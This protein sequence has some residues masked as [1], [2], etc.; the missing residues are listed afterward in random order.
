M[1][2]LG[3]ELNNKKK[4]GEP[5][6]NILFA[7]LFVS[8]L[9]QMLFATRRDD[10]STIGIVFKAGL[11]LGFLLVVIVILL[12][13]RTR[14]KIGEVFLA[15]LFCLLQIV[16]DYLVGQQ[17]I[18][19]SSAVNIMT[20]FSYYLLFYGLM[21]YETLSDKGFYR[22]AFLYDLFMMY[23]CG[24]NFVK[25]GN[26]MFNVFAITNSYEMVMRSYFSSR[27]TFGLFLLF[28]VIITV[29]RLAN[30]PTKKQKRWYW[31][32]M[33]I[34]GYSLFCTFSRTS[35]LA[36]S[37]FIMLFFVLKEKHQI[38][39]RF[40][41]LIS[42]LL[43][44]V[45]VLYLTGGY[46]FVLDMIIRPETGSTGRVERWDYLLGQYIEGN[47]LF[48][49]HS[50][51]QLLP[52][53]TYVNILIS[54]GIA[55]MIFFIA[56]YVKTLKKISVIIKYDRNYGI[57]FLSTFIAYAFVAAMTETIMP[58]ASAANSVVCSLFA[59]VLPHFYYNHVVKQREALENDSND[60]VKE[61]GNI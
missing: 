22:I 4:T 24:Y 15:V 60:E 11:Y 20:S 27:N 54:G 47:V 18:T 45:L 51:N 42:L 49:G 19:I 7:W 25:Y 21:N 52:H 40:V 26:S 2:Y 37:V 17:A 16:S 36:A 5:L 13:K 43:L 53:N 32:V 41:I 1:N 30:S 46:K 39:R 6:A 3:A 35:L 56:L 33:I 31:F 14:S 44:T 10:Q 48:G 50:D 38:A 8:L 57:F 28:G 29:F 58:I 23:A 55:M 9:P 61:F 34:T 12:K 59:L